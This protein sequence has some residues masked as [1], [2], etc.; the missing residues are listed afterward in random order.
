MQVRKYLH[1]CLSVQVLAQVCKYLRKRYASAQVQYAS[2][3][4]LAQCASTMRKYNVQVGKYCARACTS[5]QMLGK[6]LVQVL[7][8]VR[9]CLLAL[10]GIF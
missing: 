10:V 1:K 5:T 9:K 4:R 6:I 3:Q 8:Q 7:V 2:A